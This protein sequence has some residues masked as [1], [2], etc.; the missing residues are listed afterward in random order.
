VTK[1]RHASTQK[2]LYP[3]FLGWLSACDL[4]LGQAS[5]P[6]AGNYRGAAQEQGVRITQEEK[7][8]LE[9]L[10]AKEQA[11]SDLSSDPSRFIV[12]AGWTKYGKPLIDYPPPK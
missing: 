1:T 5:P 2:L 9:R 11:R 4:G 8:L 12:S 6:P 3:L 7:E 10:K